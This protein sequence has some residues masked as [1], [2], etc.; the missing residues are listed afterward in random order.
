[1]LYTSTFACAPRNIPSHIPRNIATSRDIPSHSSINTPTNMS[2]DALARFPS[3]NYS[4]R[5]SNEPESIRNIPTVTAM[6][7]PTYRDI[8]IS[9]SENMNM[10]LLANASAILPTGIKYEIPPTQPSVRCTTSIANCKNMWSTGP[11]KQAAEN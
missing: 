10:N 4:E 8:P 6:N 11:L 3:G 5:P 7:I 9:C 2:T 1:M